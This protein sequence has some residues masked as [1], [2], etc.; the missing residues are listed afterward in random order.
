MAENI[1][2]N[3]EMPEMQKTLKRFIA[4]I[5]VA[6]AS[7]L[8]DIPLTKGFPVIEHQIGSNH[9]QLIEDEDQQMDEA[10]NEEDSENEEEIA[11]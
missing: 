8:I 9:D 10:D 5:D 6:N 3:F 1:L 2:L 11:Q 7:N 4:A